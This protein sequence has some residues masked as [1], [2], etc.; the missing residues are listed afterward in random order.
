M[1]YPGS[2]SAAGVAQ[3]IISQF[4]PH[5]VYVEPF[6]GSGVIVLRK[7]PASL[8]IVC[9]LDAACVAGVVAK[10]AAVG[11]IACQRS[12]FD[13]AQQA[14]APTTA[15]GLACARESRG[16]VGVVTCGIQA[17]EAWSPAPA[18]LVYCDPPYLVGRGGGRRRR[19]YRHEISTVL[20]HARLL[21]CL[22]QLRCAVAISGY[23]CDL[24]DSRLADWRRVDYTASTRGGPVVESLW[25]NYAAPAVL[26]DPRYF[27]GD[28]RRRQDWRRMVARWENK[29]KA[30][31]PVR[32][33]AL[34]AALHSGFD[35]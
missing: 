32:R 17:L 15:A 8:S 11:F 5:D 29:L 10:A 16:L 14:F 12:L 23:R 21:S 1:G 2:K 35:R 18:S 22:C 6:V 25:C 27:G 31:D 28:R 7:L 24:Y 30:L 4:P 13:L 19:Y 33:A 26:A 20:D 3:Q 9:D 34:L